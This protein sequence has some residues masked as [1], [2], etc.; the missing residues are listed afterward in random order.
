L[1]EKLNVTCTKQYNDVGLK[2]LTYVS[3]RGWHGNNYSEKPAVNMVI[4][5]EWGRQIHI[6]PFSRGDGDSMIGISAVIGKEILL[7]PQ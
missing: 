1:T 3:V 7:V 4:Q 6:L 5:Q 2:P